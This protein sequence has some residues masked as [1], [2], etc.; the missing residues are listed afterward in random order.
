M[1]T[2]REAPPARH[3]AFAAAFFSLLLPGLGQVYAGRL[4]R[5]AVFMIPWLLAVALVAGTAAALLLTRLIASMLFGVTGSDPLSFAAAAVLLALTMLLA[6]ILP[7]RRAT[8]VDPLN[9]LR[10]D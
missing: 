10:G 7:A 2:S 1:Q 6:T 4:I 8:R 3:S 9:S 5:G